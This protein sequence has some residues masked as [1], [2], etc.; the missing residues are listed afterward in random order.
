[1]RESL[2]CPKCHHDEIVYLPELSDQADFPM[3]LHAVVRHHPFRAPT[4]WGKIEAYIC[5]K[6]G[7]TELYTREPDKIPLDAV[8]GARV[9]SRKDRAPYR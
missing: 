8:A 7:F 3:S 2:E 9:L 4:R 5:K 1:M 6:C